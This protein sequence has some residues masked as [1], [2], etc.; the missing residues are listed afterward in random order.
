MNSRLNSLEDML[1]ISFRLQKQE[2]VEG[3]AGE[4][5]ATG[6]YAFYRDRIWR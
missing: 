4:I 6:R 1:G 2:G 3:N 5:A